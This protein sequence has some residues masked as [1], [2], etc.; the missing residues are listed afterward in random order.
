MAHLARRRAQ[1]DSTPVVV[2]RRS[3]PDGSALVLCCGP[4]VIGR[5][6]TPARS[7]RYIT[8]TASGLSA[9]SQNS[10]NTCSK[11]AIHQQLKYCQAISNLLQPQRSYVMF[12]CANYERGCRGRTN[13]SNGRCADCIALNL[14]TSRSGYVS[15]STS[16]SSYSNYSN[17]SA[18]SGA[19]VSLA[20]IH[21]ASSTR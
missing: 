2:V 16:A 9:R 19:F 8:S 20:E 12:S 11:A 14:S 3:Y 6:K 7:R 15:P 4:E 13:Q 1:P 21:R 18:M 17:Y 5:L 10:P